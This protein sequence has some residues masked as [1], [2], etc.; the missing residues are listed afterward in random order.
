MGI[1]KYF[2]EEF[3]NVMLLVLSN[4]DVSDV[5]IQ[6]DVNSFLKE[7]RFFSMQAFKEMLELKIQRKTKQIRKQKDNKNK[8]FIKLDQNSKKES[9][10][11]NL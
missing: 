4:L 1:D 3:C 8:V 2:L 5:E 10:K 6:E 11:G 7:S 9:K